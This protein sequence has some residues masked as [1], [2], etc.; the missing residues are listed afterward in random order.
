[1]PEADIFSDALLETGRKLFAGEVSFLKGTSSLKDLPTDDMPEVAFAGRSN[2]G[3]SSLI[4]ALTGRKVLAR[5]SN[6]PGRT[7]EINYF[8][9]ADKFHLVDLPG[10]GYAKASK[11][12]VFDF[13]KFTQDY[14]SD[15][16][17]LKRVF[18][19]IDSRHGLKR[20]DV[21]AMVELDRLGQSYQLVL[22]K[23]D[24]VKSL[25]KVV[26]EIEAHMEKHPAC[27]PRILLTSSR[28]GEGMSYL[29]A[30]IAA[31]V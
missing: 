8:N 17:Q 14:L 28:L 16:P 25:D 24:K 7:R 21:E 31:L 5:T 1:M 13:Q 10:Y 23:A 29:R 6:T 22:T 2:V 9:V 15:R 12:I 11:Q 18:V 30:E 19:L 26:A 27:F 3:K 20:N 4:N